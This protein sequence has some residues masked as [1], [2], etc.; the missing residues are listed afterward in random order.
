MNLVDFE[1]CCKMSIWTQKS[2]SIQPRTSP[3]KFDLPPNCSESGVL[4][5]LR[6]DLW[7]AAQAASLERARAFALPALLAGAYEPMR[8]STAVGHDTSL[9]SRLVLGCIETKFCDQIRIFSGFSRS[10]KLSS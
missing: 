3:L 8:R 6:R 5:V 2:A 1:K 10:T 7:E 9:F 4:E